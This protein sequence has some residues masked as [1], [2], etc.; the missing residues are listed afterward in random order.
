MKKNTGQAATATG[1]PPAAEA[2]SGWYVMRGTSRR[3]KVNESNLS[4]PSDGEVAIYFE[5]HAMT[6]FRRKLK[7][8]SWTSYFPPS[9]AEADVAPDGPSEAPLAAPDESFELLPDDPGW[10]VLVEGWL[11]GPPDPSFSSSSSYWGV[12]PFESGLQDWRPDWFCFLG[13]VDDSDFGTS[14]ARKLVS[15]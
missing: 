2:S 4:I 10:E 1:N 7:K 8:L 3:D 9:A 12:F 15:W 14:S 13:R 11:A 5:F 6:S